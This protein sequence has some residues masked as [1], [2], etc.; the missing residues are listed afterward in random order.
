MQGQTILSPDTQ[1]NQTLAITPFVGRRRVMDYGK[2]RH[3]ISLKSA[4]SVR[5]RFRKASPPYGEGATGLIE[6]S[7]SHDRLRKSHA[8]MSPRATATPCAQ[9]RPTSPRIASRQRRAERNP[10]GRYPHRPAE[11][12]RAPLSERAPTIWQLQPLGGNASSTMNRPRT[13]QARSSSS[14]PCAATSGCGFRHAGIAGM[15][16]T[17]PAL[18]PACSPGRRGHGAEGGEC[19]SP[20]PCAGRT[21]PV[22]RAGQIV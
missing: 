17:R 21:S 15:G 1:Q 14:D 11:S 12:R 2:V 8:E 16:A 5:C 13:G 22:A 10:S 9:T 6:S 19:R 18:H 4:G 7:L 20:L 3:K